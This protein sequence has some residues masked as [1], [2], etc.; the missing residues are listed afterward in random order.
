MVKMCSW[1]DLLC[2]KKR[3]ADIFG[4]LFCK[5]WECQ[6]FCDWSAVDPVVILLAF[7]SCYAQFI[8]RC[9]VT[10]VFLE[11]LFVGTFPSM[12]GAAGV[13]H[14]N[15]IGWAASD[16]ILIWPP[17]YWHGAPMH[18]SILFS[19]F[20]FVLLWSAFC[21]QKLQNALAYLVHSCSS[22]K[23]LIVIYFC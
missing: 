15:L 7:R 23:S 11:F 8:C 2:C 13:S 14:K 9:C 16:W 20:E 3:E 19:G 18:P 21:L 6:C 10:V 17:V 12:R 5:Q 4:G 22:R 1:S